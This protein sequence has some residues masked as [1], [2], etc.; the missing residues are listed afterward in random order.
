[1]DIL[2]SFIL[3]MQRELGLSE[4]FLLSRIKHLDMDAYSLSPT[5]DGCA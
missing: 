4:K 2:E 3:Q 5:G 1:M